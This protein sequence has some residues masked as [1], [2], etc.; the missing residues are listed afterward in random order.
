MRGLG[1][2]GLGAPCCPWCVHDRDQRTRPAVTR[3]RTTHHCVLCHSV[4][5]P[6]A[7]SRSHLPVLYTTLR[8]VYTRMPPGPYSVLAFA[9]SS[10]TTARVHDTRTCR[11]RA[12]R[13]QATDMQAMHGH[14]EHGAGN[15]HGVY[16][17]KRHMTCLRVGRVWSYTLYERATCLGLFGFAGQDSR[18]PV[19]EAMRPPGSTARWWMF[20]ECQDS[21][22]LNMYVVFYG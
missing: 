18:H 19:N 12:Q 7:W 11:A 5:R 1:R 2:G 14:L 15:C 20:A 16:A 21:R 6:L 8:H 9:T 22:C 4:C 10:S 17:V 13:F 3:H